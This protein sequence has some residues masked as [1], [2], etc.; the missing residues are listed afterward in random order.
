MKGFLKSPD[1][2]LYQLA[3]S[4][5]M[6]TIGREG[7]DLI[8]QVSATNRLS[9]L[10]NTVDNLLHKQSFQ[11]TRNTGRRPHRLRDNPATTTKFPLSRMVSSLISINWPSR[12][13]PPRYLDRDRWLRGSQTANSLL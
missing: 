5:K 2:T 3:P 13:R 7:C 4:P 9:A 11:C 1:G 8:V 12:T 6:T 10:L